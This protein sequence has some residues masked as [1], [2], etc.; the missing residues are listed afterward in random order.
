MLRRLVVGAVLVGLGVMV[1]RSIPD[2]ARY[3][4]IRMM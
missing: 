2:L 4:K 3:L 1:A